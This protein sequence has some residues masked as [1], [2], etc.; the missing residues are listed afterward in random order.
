MEKSF[1]DGDIT[2]HFILFDILSTPE[3]SMTISEIMDEVDEFL[4]EFDNP[5]YFDESTIR[6][7]LKEYVN[8]GLLVAEK[9][10]KVMFKESLEWVRDCP[11]YNQVK[12]LPYEYS[13]NV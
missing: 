3:I 10:G 8:E 13:H 12:V 11:S 4:S 2:L 7:K 5:R 1:T 6:K 9:Q